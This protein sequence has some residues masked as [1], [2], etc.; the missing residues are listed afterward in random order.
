MMELKIFFMD[1]FTEFGFFRASRPRK[2]LEDA[3]DSLLTHIKSNCMAGLPGVGSWSWHDAWKHL[4]F[5]VWQRVFFFFL[6]GHK[7]GSIGG[8]WNYDIGQ[9][10]NGAS[11]PQGHFFQLLFAMG[12]WLNSIA[13][14]CV[15]CRKFKDPAMMSSTSAPRP[16]PKAC[17]MSLGPLVTRVLSKD[18]KL[19]LLRHLMQRLEQDKEK[20]PHHDSLPVCLS[21]TCS[22]VICTK[23]NI[24]LDSFW[25]A[26][27]IS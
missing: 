17:W 10:K 24:I 11:C 3:M 2:V 15:P 25:E 19:L 18:Q 12:G 13:F 23:C 27:P 6:F 14:P 21:T 9:P 4:P 26:P 1:P 22:P 7:A 20:M 5:G 16:M 8:V